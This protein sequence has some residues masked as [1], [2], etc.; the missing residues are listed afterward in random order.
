MSI[1]V[2]FMQIMIMSC[3]TMTLFLRTNLH[4][5]TVTDGG[6]YVGALFFAI[7]MLMFN[8]FLELSLTLFK[9]PVFF[10][11]RDYQFYPSWAYAIPN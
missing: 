9:L 3:I 10:K 8:G 6:I 7:V 11:Q 4:H 1:V 5:D 2:I